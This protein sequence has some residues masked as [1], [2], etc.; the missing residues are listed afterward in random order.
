MLNNQEETRFLKEMENYEI[1]KAYETDNDDD[2][3]D[4]D[5]GDDDVQCIWRWPGGRRD[6]QQKV[7]KKDK[8]GVVC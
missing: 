7:K 1:V 2:G 3:G 6:I 4:D 5:D 8:L